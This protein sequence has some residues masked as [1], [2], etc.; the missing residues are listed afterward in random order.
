M[1]KDDSNNLYFGPKKNEK[2]KRACTIVKRARR[3]R[4]DGGS[5]MSE[6]SLSNLETVSC[7]RTNRVL[8]VRRIQV[9]D[10]IEICYAWT[11]R[12]NDLGVCL[13]REMRKRERER[14]GCC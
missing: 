9:G 1:G 8:E 10:T 11:E 5:V 6:S 2:G 12:G 7:R 4:S 3:E 13:F 14:G